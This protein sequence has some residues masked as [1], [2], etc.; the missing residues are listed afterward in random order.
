MEING[1]TDQTQNVHQFGNLHRINQNDPETPGQPPDEQGPVAEQAD[2]SSGHPGVIRL[3]EEGHFK[4]TA[5]LRLRI[6]FYDQLAALEA[7][8][9]QAVAEE[10]VDGII[11]SVGTVVEGF[12]SESDPPP[13]PPAELPPVVLD[14]DGVPA[15]IEPEAQSTEETPV[16]VTELQDIFALTVTQLK[17]DFIAAQSPSTDTLLEGI[18]S[19]FDG[20]I[21]SLQSALTPDTPLVPPAETVDEETEPPPLV[22]ESQP[23]T[24]EIIDELT[25]AF[26]A[27]LQ[28]L[29]DAFS[30]ASILTPTSQ[31]NGNGVAY[32][33]FLNIYNDMRDGTV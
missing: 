29:I 1:V 11:E 26:E 15:P 18:Q 6:N 20:F 31:P 21:E 7:E 30:E 10:K 23:Q 5:D 17:E 4:G 25:A 27:A 16:D 22:L 24:P 33:K 19:A 28:E 32:D 3:L 13:E 12:S 8:K 2:G 9:M 14:G